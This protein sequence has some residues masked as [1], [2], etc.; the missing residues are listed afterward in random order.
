MRRFAAL[1]L[2]GL[3][4]L[5]P[6]LAR[7]EVDE[8]RIPVGAGGIG[9]LPLLVMEKQKLVEKHA[10]AAGLDKLKVSWIS[11]G[12]PS[13]VNDALLS[14]A[15]HFAPA[16]P[17][18]FLTMW[19]RTRGA[20]KVMGAA[21]MT[22]MPMYLNTNS[23]RIK[24]LDD[25]GG[26]DKMAVTG[27]KVSIPA[28]VMQM[29][30]RDKYG[31][32]DYA[33][34]D[35]Y[36]VSMTHPDAVV[37]LLSRRLEINLHFASPPF[38]QRELKDPGIRTVMNTDQIMGGST[39]FT[40]LYTT[41]K[42]HDENPKTYGAV[43]AGLREAIAFIKANPKEATRI[44]VEAPGGKGWAEEEI[45]AVIQ[46]PDTVFTTSPQNVMKYATFM[47]EVGTLKVKPEN[48]KELFLPD[49]HDQEGS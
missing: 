21:A 26:T 6:G 37:A 45:L 1:A 32:A 31:A 43:M 3:L 48:W 44:F 16:G 35:K 7:A 29:Y 42:F 10:A 2:A 18:A 11:F 36:T 33:R 28:I 13:V 46:S 22:S 12:G 23:D 41:Q 19:G 47:H 39:T 38:H 15:S 14:G 40:M 30:A 5:A 25:I 27:I 8:V 24:T 49:A 20:Q 9:F 4:A 17:P 34:F